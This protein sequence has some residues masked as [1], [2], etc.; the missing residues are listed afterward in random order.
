MDASDLE[1]ITWYGIIWITNKLLIQMKPL[2]VNME[3]GI[4]HKMNG[5]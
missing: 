5:L 2:N 4:E 3:V 1:G